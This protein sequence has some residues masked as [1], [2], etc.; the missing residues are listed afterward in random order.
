MTLESVAESVKEPDYLPLRVLKLKKFRLPRFENLTEIP[1][2]PKKLFLEEVHKLSGSQKK[3]ANPIVKI[4]ENGIS[5]EIY[6]F[7]PM[8]EFNKKKILSDGDNFWDKQEY[9]EDIERKIWDK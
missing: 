4:P 5:Y 7:T 1:E 6:D 2:K 9:L 8:K 3:G